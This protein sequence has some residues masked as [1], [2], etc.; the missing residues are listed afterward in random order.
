MAQIKPIQ[1]YERKSTFGN[2]RNNNEEPEYNEC[3]DTEQKKNQ[4]FCTQYI[5]FAEFIVR[6]GS[7]D[8][9]QKQSRAGSCCDLMI[10]LWLS[11]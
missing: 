8:D 7:Q 4:L 3:E 1:G 9:T 11:K 5:L 2:N 6:V 10:T